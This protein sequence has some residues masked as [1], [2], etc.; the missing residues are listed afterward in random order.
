MHLAIVACVNH[1]KTILDSLYYRTETEDDSKSVKSTIDSF[2]IPV[3]LQMQLDTVM[4]SR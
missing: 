2:F 4:V 3:S 1:V